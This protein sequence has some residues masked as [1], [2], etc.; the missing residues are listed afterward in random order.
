[1]C[2]RFFGVNTETFDFSQSTMA[3]KAKPTVKKAKVVVA[4][5]G[6]VKRQEKKTVIDKHAFHQKDTGSVPVQVA[7]LTE[8]IQ[9]LTEHL[10]THP[11][12]DHGRRG[13]MIAVGKRRKLLK[14]LKDKSKIGYEELI[15]T[16][17]LR[18]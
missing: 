1:M 6:P 17:G 18:H 5:K 11:N 3:D 15:Q 16:L 12:D 8:R 4:A 13:L 9:H 7:I 2:L 14:Y 10:K